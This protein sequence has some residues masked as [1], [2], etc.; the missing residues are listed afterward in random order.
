MSRDEAGLAPFLCTGGF[1]PSPSLEGG[2]RWRPNLLANLVHGLLLA[3]W[4]ALGV[5]VTLGAPGRA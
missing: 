2:T 4:A 3:A 5:L 1:P